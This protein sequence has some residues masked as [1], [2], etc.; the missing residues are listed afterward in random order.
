MRPFLASPDQVLPLLEEIHQNRIYSNHGPLV[1]RLESEYADFLNVNP[2]RVAVLSNA[3]LALQACL[4]FSSVNNWAIPDF[5]FAATAVAAIRASKI[6]TLCDIRNDNFKLDTELI[7]EFQDSE[8]GILP[9]MPFGAPIDFSEFIDFQN[10]VIDAAASLGSRM[11]DFNAMPY[12]WCTV[13]SLHATKVLGCGEGGLIVTNPEKAARIRSWANFGFLGSRESQFLA[14]N[15]KM[16][17]ITAAY[18]LVS[19]QNEGKERKSWETPISIIN[20]LMSGSRFNTYLN[21]IDGYRPYWIIRCR[22]SEELEE[23]SLEMKNLGIETRRWWAKPLHQMPAFG[24]LAKKDDLNYSQLASETVLG[25]P[26]FREITTI[27]IEKIVN[28]LQG[29]E[30]L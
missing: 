16:P 5:T 27:E 7:T 9:V 1:K 6:V 3:T 25:L 23:I 17:E 13:F 14:T 20:N 15:A 8:H 4:E 21:N 29:F 2:D 19:L 30:S 28:V 26:L 12:E 10:V 11:P 18:G 24:H 22:D